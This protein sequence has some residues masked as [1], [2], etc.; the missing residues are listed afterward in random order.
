MLSSERCTPRSRP[1]AH[2]Y[3]GLDRTNF[4]GCAA[5]SRVVKVVF[6]GILSVVRRFP[7]VEF[8]AIAQNDYRSQGALRRCRLEQGTRRSGR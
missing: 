8:V 2:P 7:M 1:T 5:E 3:A 6:G 4:S